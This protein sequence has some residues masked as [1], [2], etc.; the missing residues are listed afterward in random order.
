MPT[1]ISRGFEALVDF[2]KKRDVIT[3]LGVPRFTVLNALL[4]FAK[5]FRLDALFLLLPKSK[6]FGNV[7]AH[8][9]VCRTNS[10][11]A[12]IPGGR[13]LITPSPLSSLPAVML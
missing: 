5:T 8:S 7:E 10:V 2:P 4:M 12:R 11:Q 13:S 6:C 1:S 9:A 3:P